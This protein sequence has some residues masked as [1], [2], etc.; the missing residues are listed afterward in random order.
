[1]IMKLRKK[2]APYSQIAEIMQFTDPTGSWSKAKAHRIV[3]RWGSLYLLNKQ[4]PQ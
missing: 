4:F 1:M 2:K 3:K